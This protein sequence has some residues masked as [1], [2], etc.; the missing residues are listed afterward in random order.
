MVKIAIDA[1]HGLNTSGKRTPDNEREWSFNNK[2]ALACIAEL[3]TYQNVQTLRLDDPTGKTDVP[4]K[5]RTDKANS[6]NADALVSCHPN[7]YLGRWGNHGG[8]ETITQT[9]SQKASLDIAKEIHPRVVSAMGLAD[10]GLKTMNLHVT[11]ESHMPAV[12][13]EGGFMDSSID[14]IAMRSDTK[15]KAQGEAIAEGLAA[16]FKLDKKTV[17][18]YKYE[19]SGPGVKKL[20]QDLNKT[21]STLVED[22]S[23]GSAVRTAVRQFQLNHKLAVDGIAG[24]ITLAKLEEVI[25]QSPIPPK[26]KDRLYRVIVDGK[27][28]G[29]YSEDSNIM[30]QVDTELKNNPLEIKI[31][32][33]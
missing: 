6:W 29:A 17:I 32:K 3:N 9:V 13:V 28:V 22:G 15:L 25:K 26:Q 2:V 11:R 4:L 30:A 18:I 7:A 1:G 20:Q 24:P 27:Q 33:Q 14:I 5:T 21:G 10:R 19:D 12:L 23:F 16:Y 8:V 31:Q